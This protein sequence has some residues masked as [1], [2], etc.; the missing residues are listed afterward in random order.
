MSDSSFNLRLTRYDEPTD[1]GALR[2]FRSTQFGWREER[3]PES[4]SPLDHVTNPT[5]AENSNL[6]PNEQ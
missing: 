2:N 3:G 1:R 6:P 5:P 4:V